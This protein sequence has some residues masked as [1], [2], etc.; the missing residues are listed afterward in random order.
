M[1]WVAV[2]MLCLSSF[3]VAHAQVPGFE[4]VQPGLFGAPE[5]LTNAWADYD[6][7]GDFD[8]FVGF[9]PNLPN[10]LYRNDDGVF[11]DV[12][13]EVG[14]ADLDNTRAAAWGDFNGDGHIDLYV[15]FAPPAE[16]SNTLYQNDGDGRHFTNVTSSTG[17][18]LVTNTRQ[19]ALFTTTLAEA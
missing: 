12:A 1:R 5:T 16:R 14:I 7:D 8:L 18:E 19:P 9:R 15:G 6:N 17:V 4:L 10:R 13:A 11:V 3:S 2:A